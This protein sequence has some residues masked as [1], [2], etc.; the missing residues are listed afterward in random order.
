LGCLGGLPAT[1][2]AIDKAIERC[3]KACDAANV[4]KRREMRRDLQEKVDAVREFL[5]LD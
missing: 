2:I 5:G 1:F 4:R 3:E